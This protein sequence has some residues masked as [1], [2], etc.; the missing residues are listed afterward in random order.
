VFVREVCRAAHYWTF[1]LGMNFTPGG[2][3]PDSIDSGHLVFSTLAKHLD[4]LIVI[5][6][7]GIVFHPGIPEGHR[8]MSSAGGVNARQRETMCWRGGGEL[9]VTCHI[10]R[11]R[12]ATMTR[13]SLRK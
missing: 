10:P 8:I 4:K 13:K 9:G 3:R 12:G 11:R 6:E 1:E 2:T 7:S 5:E